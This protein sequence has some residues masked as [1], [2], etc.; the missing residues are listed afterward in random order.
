MPTIIRIIFVITNTEYLQISICLLLINCPLTEIINFQKPSFR[1]ILEMKIVQ[2]NNNNIYFK[3]A[4]SATQF[5]C[6][7]LIQT[8]LL[9][10]EFLEKTNNKQF[11]KKNNIFS[12]ITVNLREINFV[13]KDGNFLPKTSRLTAGRIRISFF[14]RNN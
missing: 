2:I 6:L 10:C 7:W 4:N 1:D 3:S 12:S 9:I 11:T 13:L 5:M 14:L 8:I